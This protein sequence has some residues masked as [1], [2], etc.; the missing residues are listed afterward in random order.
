MIQSTPGERHD[1]DDAGTR[2]VRIEAEA[3]RLVEGSESQ[4]SVTKIL[5]LVELTLS[6][7]IKASPQRQ[8]K[9]ADSRP[10]SA[11]RWRWRDG[12]SSGPR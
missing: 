12:V 8:L 11:D 1:E 7:R 3:V 4:P 6:N 2:Q 5:G 9:G 10:V